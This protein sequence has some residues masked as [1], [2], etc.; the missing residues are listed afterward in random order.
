MDSD[1][2]KLF[3][4]GISW[5]TSEEKLKE[6]F[7]NYG[8]VVQT[9]IMRDKVTGRPR[10]F[11]FVVFAD[12]SI[13]D[14][15]LQD[16][17]TIDGRTVEA[18]RALSREEQQ[19]SRSGNPNA[20]RNLG[21]AGNIKTK[22]IFVGGLPP[23][24]TEEGFRQY[25]ET[26]GHVTDVV[27]MYDQTTQRPRGFGF[28]SF[29][30]EEAVDR[31]LHKT[32]HELNGKLVEVKRALPKEANPGSGGRQMGG[33]SYQG[34]GGSG[35]NA[36]TYD[37]RVD[38]ARYMP[39]QTAGGGFPAYGSS[40]YGA[41]GYGYGAASN[42]VGYGGYGVGGYGSAN[43]GYSGPAGA[44]ANPNAPN[45]GYVSGPGA[46]RSPWNS[47]APTGYGSA[48]YGAN[49]GYGSAAHW[50]S[51][52]GAAGAGNAVSAPTGQ[53]PSG[54]ANYGNHGYGY[55]GYGGGDGSY[56]NPSSYGAVGGRAGSA[57]NS[58]SGAGEQQ[59]AGGGYMGSG[60]GDA[61]GYP[62]AVWRSDAS[63]A[64]SYGTA[65]ANGPPSGQVGYGGGYGG[66]AQSRQ[67]QQ[68]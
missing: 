59:G 4:G 41:P 9:V 56:G 8:E 58:N 64:G 23:T 27:V 11:G 10:G 43:A 37:S 40:G 44:Y 25:F 30:T 68:Q 65:H 28:I 48:G 22:K 50:N 2:G 7:G 3:V 1:Q 66:G 62:N 29:D 51:P 55:G 39:P 54:A 45:A 31:V 34:Y 67:A 5:D 21:G 6:Y 19:T 17:H 36:N 14:R 24:L 49:A 42:G 61:N 16:K 60:Y 20:G 63:Q 12:P 33:G 52:S 15:V 47:Q 57:P 13:L 53:S 35:G 38:A 32:F 46:P 26:Y 18:K